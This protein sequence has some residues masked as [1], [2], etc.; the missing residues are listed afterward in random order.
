M[1]VENLKSGGLYHL[2][3][4]KNKKKFE[5]ENQFQHPPSLSFM[6]YKTQLAFHK[7]VILIGAVSGGLIT[8]K[9]VL[10]I[11]YCFCFTL[12][13]MFNSIF[14][15]KMQLLYLLTYFS[16]LF[17]VVWLLNACDFIS[18]FCLFCVSYDLG[19][20]LVMVLRMLWYCAQIV[21]LSQ[22]LGYLCIYLI[23]DLSVSFGCA[24]LG[25]NNHLVFQEIIS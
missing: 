2:G 16:Y 24:R 18:F 11:H 17:S 22:N 14:F 20:C 8:L 6:G 23:K 10:I 1:E 12:R 15:S 19:W 3:G 7:Q 5:Q 13:T 9:G 25:L 21:F 4:L